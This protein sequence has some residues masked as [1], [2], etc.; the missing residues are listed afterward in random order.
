MLSSYGSTSFLGAVVV[1][2]AVAVSPHIM[3]IINF[4]SPKHYCELNGFWRKFTYIH[5]INVIL[6]FFVA[7]LR[8]Y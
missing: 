2:A 1:A 4:S 7:A 3:K 6:R 8:F 5:I